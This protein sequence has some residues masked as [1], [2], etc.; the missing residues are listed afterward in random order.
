MDNSKESAGF[1]LVEVLV[2]TVVIAIIA[3][4]AAVTLGGALDKAKQGATIA[5]MRNLGTAINAYQV[6]HGRPPSGADF[7]EIAPALVPYAS[8]RLSVLD[9]WGN[10]FG[11]ASD[12]ANYSLISF[13]K[14]GVDGADLTAATK[15][16]FERD[17]VLWNGE[18][19]G[20]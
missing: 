18:F 2:V 14:D 20:L 19:L 13:G 17:I 7:S 16:E 8:D 12:A 15:K 3:A 5:D 6:D 10:V 11:Y 9:H 1:T 4:I